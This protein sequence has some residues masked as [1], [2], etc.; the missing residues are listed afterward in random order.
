MKKVL[1]NILVYL[2]HLLSKTWRFKQNGT[3][4]TGPAVLIFWHR[5]LL[6]GWKF[7]SKQGKFFAVVSPSRDGEYLVKLLSKWQFSFIRGSSDKN[8]K[9]VMN[10]LT[11]LAKYNSVSL[12]PDG[13]KG[14]LFKLKP[15]AVVAAYRAGV[16]IQFIK[17]NSTKNIIFKK[18]WD[19]FELPFPFST[20][21]V[22][23]SE[24][25][26]IPQTATRDEIDKLIIRIEELMKND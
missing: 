15:G 14:P 16:P 25:I 11:E 2:V 21:N 13:P 23:I 1:L 24:P 5:Y 22:D 7:L 10:K 9:E 20:I 3:L 6:A 18:S 12:T 8:S 4:I 17:I 26:I 19:K